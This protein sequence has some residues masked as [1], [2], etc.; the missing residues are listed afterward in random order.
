MNAT[1]APRASHPPFPDPHRLGR[2]EG[3]GGAGDVPGHGAGGPAPKRTIVGFGFWVFLLSDIIMFAAIFAAF[4]VLRDATA[5][6]PDGAQLFDL[7]N[8]KLETICLLF[9]SFA[10]G[11]ALIAAKCR[12]KGWAQIWLIV[13]GVLG[14]VFLT[15]EIE[16]FASMIIEGA[17]PQ[18]SA[19]LS[20]FFTLVGCHGLHVTCG[21]VWLLIMIAQIQTLDFR[22]QVMR[23]L[24]C[25]GLFWH[26]L[27]IIWVAVLTIVYL[28]GAKA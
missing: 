13:T 14:A 27:D 26:A 3:E 4:A 16:E 17:G 1:L 22:P 10:C 24:M 15:L 20:A 6:G 11:I 12:N 9:S 21:L 23:R 28:M 2:G 19:F 8:A 5:G 7:A 18:R 25:F